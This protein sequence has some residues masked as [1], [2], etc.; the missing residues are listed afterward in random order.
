[1]GGQAA[2]QTPLLNLKHSAHAVSNLVVNVSNHLLAEFRVLDSDFHLM[3][4]VG[5]SSDGVLVVCVVCVHFQQPRCV[6]DK[7]DQS[8]ERVCVFQKP[9][10]L[11]RS[12]LEYWPQLGL[13][14]ADKL[15]E[16]FAR[17]ADVFNVPFLPSVQP[18]ELVPL[19]F[20]I[21]S[22]C[23]EHGSV[24]GSLAVQ[25]RCEVVLFLCWP[26]STCDFCPCYCSSSE[27]SCTVSCRCLVLVSSVMSSRDVLLM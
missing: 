23:G 11:G 3:A 21:Q 25:R 17:A 7:K 15:V 22:T 6:F 12:S 19:F 2:V 27:P 14:L 24:C 9:L 16:P 10:A 5:E 4:E 18:D 13:S 1:M 20:Q 26:R 8:G